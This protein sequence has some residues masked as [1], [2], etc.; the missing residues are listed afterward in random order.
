MQDRNRTTALFPS[1]R[2]RAD[3]GCISDSRSL[4]NGNREEQPSDTP[5]PRIRAYA[6]A[7]YTANG[8][9]R[10]SV[11]LFRIS[12]LFLRLIIKSRTTGCNTTAAKARRRLTRGVQQMRSDPQ[13]PNALAEK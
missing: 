8:T 5:P 9:T 4:R 12:S 3:N 13:N 10:K 11:F 2:L 6:H 7:R 1:F